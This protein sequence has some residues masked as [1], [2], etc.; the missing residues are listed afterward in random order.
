M[1]ACRH[2]G[3]GEPLLLIHGTA[4]DSMSWT[5]LI[6]F[7]E[8]HF[9]LWTLDRR[10]HGN[11][12]DNAV[13]SLQNEAE[14]IAAVIKAIGTKIHVFGHSFGGLCALEAALL[15]ENIT[16]LMLYEPPLSLAGSGWSAE[17]DQQMQTLLNT[18]E[19]EQVVL[20]FL[21]EV[22]RMNDEELFN[23]QTGVNWPARIAEAHTVL[24]ELQAIDRYR[25]DAANFHNLHLPALILLGSDSPSRRHRIA[26][27][28]KNTLSDSQLVLLQDQ[29]HSAVRTAPELLA[30]KIIEFGVQT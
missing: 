14:D 29:Q 8:S 7:L 17:L 4:G 15:T 25:F 10:G 21:R 26:E 13:Y 11:S 23:L 6:P 28:L 1:I 27:T 3:R 2:S 16:S 9:T 20:L 18:G 12:G 24:R 19:K 30:G 5:P 22:L